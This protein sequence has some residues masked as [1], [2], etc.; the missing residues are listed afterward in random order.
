M[1][2]AENILT[3]VRLRPP[4]AHERKDKDAA[5]CVLINPPSNVVL[6]DAAKQVSL[7]FGCNHAFDSSDPSSDTFSTQE[8]NNK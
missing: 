3:G 6:T 4:L 8:K 2:F 5:V 7:T 1:P